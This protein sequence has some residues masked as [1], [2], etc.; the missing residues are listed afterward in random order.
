MTTE[1]GILE[2]LAEALGPALDKQREGQKHSAS[3]TPISVG[4]AHGPGGLLTFPGV[5][6]V[7]F[8]T[9]MGNRSMLGML[10][11][12]P[13]LYTNPTYYTI[14]GVQDVSG[15]EADGNCDAAPTAGL[16]KACL[17]TS[18]FGRY[19]RAT[20]E[21]ELNRVGQRTDRADPIDLTLI[22]SPIHGSGIFAQGPG[23]P[24][25]PGDIFVNE[26][27]QKMWE[28]GVAMHRLLSQEL[29]I[30][31]PA[32]DAGE[33]G[34]KKQMTGFDTLI[35]TGH[36]DAET[37]TSCPSLD[38][39]LP[40]A[41]YERV[42]TDGD[43]LVAW[44]TAL[45]HEIKTRAE[46]SGVMPV[47]WVFAMRPQLFYELT[48]VWPCSY[49]TYRCN[50]GDNEQINVNAPEHIELRDAMRVGRYLLVDGEKIPVV[51]DDGIAEEGDADNA[52]VPAGCFASDI[53]LIPMSVI[54]GR[55]VTFLEYFNFD[56]P[57]LKDGLGNMVL[58]KV[59]GAF[60]TVPLQLRQCF[61]FETKIEPRLVLRTPWLAGR[62][63]NVLYCPVQHERDPFPGGDYH[64]DGGKTS[65]PGPSLF[66]LWGSA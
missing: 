42:D 66:T 65:R 29:W 55:A 27:S 56:N 32:N 41:N 46:M 12:T 22:G 58:G 21:L 35:N 64:V 38:S 37:N 7:V 43:N 2:A 47:R 18:V 59:E 3:G 1:A 20:P 26:V 24:S 6:P 31:N 25:V 5:D 60:L 44:I 19:K 8:H 53:Y 36:V 16:K 51:L 40:D 28:L 14:T 4:Y 52:N 30:G 39:Y 34:S 49:L 23:D 61:S 50:L 13:S 48:A 15:D 63:Q 45:Y 10:P 33:Q 17:T 57:A 11:T 9:I 62:L 54:G